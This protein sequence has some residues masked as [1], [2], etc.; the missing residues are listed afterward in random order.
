MWLIHTVLDFLNLFYS[1]INE[2]LKYLTLFSV[3]ELVV[4]PTTEFILIIFGIFETDTTQI[5]L[6]RYETDSKDP[7]C[8]E[9]YTYNDKIT[10]FHSKHRNLFQLM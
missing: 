1:D 2:P 7:K 8:C 3:S 5:L 4:S 9:L 10:S 6:Y